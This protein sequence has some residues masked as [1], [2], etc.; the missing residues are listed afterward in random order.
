[1]L[2]GEALV[3]GVLRTPAELLWNGGIGTYVKGSDEA[4]ADA[5]DPTNDAV[6]VNAPD[7]RCEVVGEGGNLGL[8]Q[9]ARVEYALL[10]GRL[11]TDALDNSAGVDMSDHEVNLKILMAPAVSAGTMSVDRRNDLLEA[12]TEAVAQHVLSNN[13]SQSL[14][15]SLDEQRAKESAD[16]FR[17]FM[18]A[19]EKSGHLDR[20]AAGLPSRDVLAERREGGRSLVRPE[21]CVLLAYSKLALKDEL[22][23]SSLPEAPVTESYLA[24]Y[25]PPAA[26]LASGQPNLAGH[27]LRREIIASR[28]T[29]DLVDLM[30]STFVYRVARDTGSSTELVV[31]A[32]LIASRLAEHRALLGLIAEQRASH[33]RLTYRWLLGLGRVLERTTRWVLANVEPGEAPAVVIERNLEGLALLRDAFG[34]FVAGDDRDLFESLVREIRELGA[35]ADFA[36]TL[37]TLRFLDQLLEI[38]E[39]ARETHSDPVTTAHAYYRASELFDV[40]WLRR[41]AFAAAGQGH[42]E[43][44][45]AQVI[46]DD[47]SGAHRRLV[48]SLVRDPSA[49]DAKEAAAYPDC[50][51][52]HDVD[53]F[54]GILAELRAEES[55]GLAALSVAA[56][57]LSM[58]ADR[59]GRRAT[60]ERRG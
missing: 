13:R 58:L 27:R 28:L 48:L 4:H 47:L 36:K 53:R 54:N 23:R 1:A 34:E 11:N 30:G 26:V 55:V 19:L 24:G 57:E 18:F 9:R 44:R 59:V 14:A 49:R 56:R 37:I 2:D 38:L 17:D 45:A 20:V 40:P 41:R 50:L 51:A 25:F 8:T 12:L 35:D 10:G 5:G 15:I 29:S 32:W 22:L 42:W 60:L 39:I 16:D 46:S 6:R 7:L 43:H 31:R 33:V 52:A 21:L 3:R